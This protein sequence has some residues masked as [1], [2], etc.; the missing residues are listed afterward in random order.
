MIIVANFLFLKG[1]CISLFT[2]ILFFDITLVI[3]ESTPFLSTT[4]ILSSVFAFVPPKAK[5]LGMPLLTYRYGMGLSLGGTHKLTNEVGL[6]H[7]MPCSNTRPFHHMI[8]CTNNTFLL[9]KR[10]YLVKH[11]CLAILY[12]GQVKALLTH[13]ILKGGSVSCQ[14]NL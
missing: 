7:P 9:L 6:F 12:V 1:F 13:I 10:T 2:E 14:I 8:S 3:E 5:I 4:S 11:L